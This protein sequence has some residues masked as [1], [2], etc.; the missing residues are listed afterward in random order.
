MAA[1]AV[2]ATAAGNKNATYKLI[3]KARKTG[4]VFQTKHVS[5]ISDI[6]T[7]AYQHKY[8]EPEVFTAQTDIEMTVELLSTGVAGASIS[9]GF[10]L[11]LVNN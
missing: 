11:V 4:G 3:L 6:G 10:D 2:A 9:A 7:N 8:E 5:S 1:G